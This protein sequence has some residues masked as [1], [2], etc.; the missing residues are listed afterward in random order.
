VVNTYTGKSYVIFGKTNTEAV[1]L[2]NISKVENT[3]AHAIAL[4]KYHIRFTFVNTND[5][6]PISTNNQ[7]TQTITINIAC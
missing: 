1:N 5:I 7:I 3:A 4:T 2:A 6:C